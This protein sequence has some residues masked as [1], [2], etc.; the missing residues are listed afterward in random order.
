ME[1]GGLSLGNLAGASG[2]SGG[3][4]SGLGAAELAAKFTSGLGDS[5]QGDKA[6]FGKELTSLIDQLQ[7]GEI[8][9]QQFVDQ[10]MNLLEKYGA[11]GGGKQA[12]QGEQGGGGAEK[13]PEGGGG[14]GS[15]P[16]GASGG[17]SPAGGGDPMSMLEELLRQLGFSEDEINQVKNQAQEKMGEQGE[18]AATTAESGPG[19]GGITAM[20]QPEAL[21]A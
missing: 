15:E 1:Q 7:N 5:I 10:L 9:K 4:S 20:P 16:A 14:G 13:S 18:D 17:G 2:L 3:G 12:E 11:L 21:P 19:A 6:Q 8:S